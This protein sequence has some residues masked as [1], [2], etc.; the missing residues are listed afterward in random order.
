MKENVMMLYS[1]KPSHIIHGQTME[2]RVPKNIRGFLWV[3]NLIEEAKC[4]FA[5][6]ELK[7]Y[8]ESWND[9]TMDY[10]GVNSKIHRS[11]KI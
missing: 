2:R 7:S 6:E 4:L 9:I 10:T 5:S 8:I 1:L 3:T 11:Y